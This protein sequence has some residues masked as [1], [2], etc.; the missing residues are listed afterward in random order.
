MKTPIVSVIVPVF[1]MERYLEQTLDSLKKQSLKGL[2][3]LIVD[4]SSEDSTPA[5][6]QAYCKQHAHFK[7][8]T[9]PRVGLAASRNEGLRLATGKYVTFLDGDDLYTPSFLKHMVET[10]E[11]NAA[12]MTVGR[13]RSFDIFGIHI[14]ASAGELSARKLTDRFDTDLIW[15]PS[16]SNKLFLRARV[17]ELGLALPDCGLAQEAVFT[18][19]FALNANRIAASRRGFTEH[20]TRGLDATVKDGIADLEDYLKGYEM[21]RAAALAR[22][23]KEIARAQSAFDASELERQRRS[24]LDEILL[25]ELTVILYRYYRRFH[26][27]DEAAMHTV[28]DT[29]EALCKGLSSRACKRLQKTN[30]DIFRDGALLRDADEMAR[31]PL[32]CVALCPDERIGVEKLE[33][34][35][36]ALFSQAMPVFELAVDE[37]LRSIFPPAFRERPNVR[38]VAAETRADFKQAALDSTAAAYIQFLEAFVLLDNK[39]LQRHCAAL[40]RD[41]DCGFSASAVGRFDGEHTIEYKSSTLAFYHNPAARTT[42]DS[43]AYA[44]DLFFCNK[45]F[46]VKHLQGIKFHFTEN[47][48]LD[49][50]KLYAHSVFCKLLIR[51]IYLEITEN[52]LMAYLREYQDLLPPECAPYYRHRKGMYYRK[53][54][55]KKRREN[56]KAAL[57]TLKRWMTDGFFKTAESVY[58]R[59]PLKQRAFFYSI[60]ANGNLLENSRVVHDALDAKKITRARMLPHSFVEQLR[61]RRLLLTSKVIV[62]DD[63]V[64]YLRMFRLR[65]EQKVV[66]LWH[67]CGAFK[68]FGLDAPSQLTHLEELRTHAQYTAVCVSSEHCRQ[69]YAHAFGI[70]MEKVLATGVPRTDILLDAARRRE[71]RE[72]LL[73]KHPILDGKKVILF[74]PTFREVNGKITAYDPQIDWK[75]LNGQLADDEFVVIHNHP[76]MR[77][78]YLRGRHYDKLRDYTAEPFFELLA[79]ADVVVTDYSSV[80]FDASLLGTP[81]VFY[82][83]DFDTYERDFY[84]DY[85]ADLPGPV[86]YTPDALLPTVREVLDRPPAEKMDAFVQSQVG[87]C[88][89]KATERVAALIQEYLG[90]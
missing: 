19:T 25:K 43:R 10:A 66:Q 37:R 33:R 47:S 15:N 30:A 34:M 74:C 1:N 3:V 23:D 65:E 62:T 69:F 83:P 21:I 22:F 26:L 32:V 17:E 38:F 53:V 24:Y 84:L 36:T 13:M 81:M 59:L 46:R 70:P 67:A 39:V 14:F 35:V 86:A 60:R 28:C 79:L 48:P 61:M 12:Q 41:K 90:G 16:L 55:L 40:A 87:S 58:R 56:A 29:V 57:K 68:R 31:Q 72:Q 76:V 73:K 42:G 11:K 18:M 49:V 64:R 52:E 85:P 54:V 78:D 89:G 80:I 5:I 88:D 63:Y 27:L 20:R 51:G 4:D 75:A 8:V 45:L 2:E 82:C 77:E 44:L 6:I 50:H 9:L 71:L 7:S